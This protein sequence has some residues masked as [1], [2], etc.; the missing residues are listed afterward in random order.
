MRIYFLE[1]FSSLSIETNNARLRVINVV[2]R[3]YPKNFDIGILI[4]EV[5]IR[6]YKFKINL[7][8]F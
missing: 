6:F 5:R 4:F 3:L 8:F 7:M 2:E 1:I